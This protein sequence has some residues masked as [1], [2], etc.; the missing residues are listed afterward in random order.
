MATVYWILQCASST[1]ARVFTS[2]SCFTRFVRSILVSSFS[3]Y[4]KWPRD[5]SPLRHWSHCWQLRTTILTFIVTLQL[6]LR[7]TR[8]SI[9]NSFCPHPFFGLV[10]SLFFYLVFSLSFFWFGFF[11]AF[12]FVFY[13]S[14]FWFGFG[15]FLFFFPCNFV[16]LLV[17]FFSFFYWLGFFPRP[18]FGLVWSGLQPR[19]LFQ[20]WFGSSCSTWLEVEGVW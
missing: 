3:S 20:P 19:Q 17:W 11:L 4:N 14:L 6:R 12:L 18:F 2:P 8:D 9:W 16:I 13:S 15:L 7:V 5:L 10:F 1:R